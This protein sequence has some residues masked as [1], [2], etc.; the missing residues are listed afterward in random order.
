MGLS[1]E[2]PLERSLDLS[3]FPGYNAELNTACKSNTLSAANRKSTSSQRRS[4]LEEHFRTTSYR[5]QE[6]RRGGV[7][8]DLLVVLQQRG[9]RNPEQR[10]L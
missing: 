8:F 10:A 6:Q 1:E 4:S 7:G 5:L 2:K 9:Q 3:I